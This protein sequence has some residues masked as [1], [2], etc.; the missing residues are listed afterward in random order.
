MPIY[1]AQDKAGKVFEID[2]P[3]GVD[4]SAAISEVMGAAPTKRSGPEYDK[5]ITRSQISGV[6]HGFARSL[7]GIGQ[8]AEKGVGAITGGKADTIDKLIARID[9]SRAGE[10]KALGVEGY[11]WPQLAGEVLGPTLAVGKIAPAATWYNR[12]AQG[13][14][15]GAVAALS[16]PVSSPDYWTEKAKQAGLGAAYGTTLSGLTETGRGVGRLVGKMIEPTTESGRANILARELASLKPEGA[17]GD[18]VVNALRNAEEIVPGSKPT[19]GQAVSG[20]PEA[21]GLSSYQRAASRVNPESQDFFARQIEQEAARSGAL[22]KIAGNADDLSSAISK[23]TE[24]AAR[25]YGRAAGKAV[26]LRG[27][28]NEIAG[29]PSMKQAMAIAGEIAKEKGGE[30]RFGVSTTVDN[31]HNVKLALD[32]MVRNPEQYALGKAQQ[33][34]VEKTRSDFVEWLTAKSPEYRYARDQFA[35]MSRPINRMEVLQYL[36]ARLNPALGNRESAAAFATAAE[37]APKTLKKATGFARYENL[38][39]VLNADEVKVV[40]GV[41][42]DLKRTAAFAR[43]AS[44]TST[45]GV[46]R[47][48]GHKLPNL[49]SRPAMVMNAVLRSM[50][51]DADAKINKMAAEMFLDP[52]KLARALEG[53][54]TTVSRIVADGLVQ[55]LTDTGI[56][57][58][59]VMAAQE[60]PQ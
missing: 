28:W 57:A 40:Q 51:K 2:V 7:L 55:R 37:D 16:Q 44:A 10:R 50:G 1:E 53:K 47:S 41:A 3:D 58:G 56:V 60:R 8:L 22:G 20:I 31:L 42:A 59:S 39:D 43:Q 26:E 32:G 14:G 21:T 5:A 15:K 27:E 36:K 12:I 46:E 9:A 23:R 48:A 54:D 6:G 4:P 34:A 38:S 49:L 45:G 24:T 13:A 29:R 52:A 19:A 30:A 11:D 25:N 18:D 17:A 35:S 33:D